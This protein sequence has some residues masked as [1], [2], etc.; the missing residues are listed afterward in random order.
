MMIWSATCIGALFV[1]AIV[2]VAISKPWQKRQRWESDD[3]LRQQ[4]ID[5]GIYRPRRKF[6][7]LK[8]VSSH[9]KTTSRRYNFHKLKYNRKREGALQAI[10]EENEDMTE[11]MRPWPPTT[12]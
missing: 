2:A 6:H 7:L 3:E 1:L 5:S 4:L 9:R 11:E 12:A 10:N 8:F